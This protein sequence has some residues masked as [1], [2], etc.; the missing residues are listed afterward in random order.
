MTGLLAGA[1]SLRVVIALALA[2]LAS[3]ALNVWQFS[4]AAERRGAATAEQ[5]RDTAT[6]TVKGYT[7]L[8]AQIEQV[9]VARAA[10]DL[11]LAAQRA[12]IRDSVP[13]T[14]TVYREGA[15]QMPIPAC[16]A[17]AA[18]IDALNAVLQ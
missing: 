15:S 12:A 4:N 9:A 6:A 5:Q 1:V 2:L 14:V 11:E 8:F 10:D 18:Q 16:R 13:R 7:S 3:G 17:S